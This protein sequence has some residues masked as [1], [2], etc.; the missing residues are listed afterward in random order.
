MIQRLQRTRLRHLA[1]I[2]ESYPQ[3]YH[4]GHYCGAGT[5]CIGGW[6]VWEFGTEKE[7][8]VMARVLGERGVM[9]LTIDFRTRGQEILGLTDRQR[10]V[11]FAACPPWKGIP[12]RAAWTL[13]TLAHTGTLPG[14]EE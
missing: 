6:A 5:M 2:I 3:E 14:A 9:S 7:R 13:R 1:N 10:G 8:T 4:Q 11:L 12:Q